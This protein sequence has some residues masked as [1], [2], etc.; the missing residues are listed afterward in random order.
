MVEILKERPCHLFGSFHIKTCLLLFII[1]FSMLFR[2][3]FGNLKLG[4]ISVKFRTWNT[5]LMFL[6][7][8]S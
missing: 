5:I 2:R 8:T 6:V 7:M 4:K 1:V 3:I